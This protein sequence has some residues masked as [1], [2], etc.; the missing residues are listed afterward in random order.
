[1]AAEQ[2]EVAVAL[3]WI[4]NV[5]AL[6]VVIP[7]VIYLANKLIRAAVASQRYA[8]EIL[9]H[10]V[11]ITGNLDPVPAL[12]RTAELSAVA[13]ANAVAYVTAL[14]NMV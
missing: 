10:G 11:G 4:A 1:M 6:L 8:A 12:G 9:T 5:V 14:R 2:L 7:L 3:W 13:K